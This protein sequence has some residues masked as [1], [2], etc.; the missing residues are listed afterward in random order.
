MDNKT[1]ISTEHFLPPD[2]EVS[3][4]ALD[5]ADGTH[6]DTHQHTHGQLLYTTQGTL[7]VNTAQGCWVVPCNYGLWIPAEVAHWTRTL[8]TAH[9]RTLYFAPRRAPAMPDEC[10]VY[11]ISNLVRELIIEASRV[12]IGVGEGSRQLRLIGFLLDELVVARVSAIYLPRPKG[13]RLEALCQHLVQNNAL[14]W[15][16]A[17]CAGFLGINIKTV[18]RWFH[19]DVQMSFGKWRKQ[20]R[21]LI[22]LDRLAQGHNILEV[23][24]DAGYSTPSA[25]TAMFKREFGLPPRSFQQPR[26]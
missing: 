3:A 2:R 7:M 22:A 17:E 20:A 15:G 19:E 8:G 16:L 26:R 5:L 24:L 11:A 18:Q 1:P 23:S 13:Q 4:L 25:F 10:A 14:D 12:D 6:I 21:L 9:I